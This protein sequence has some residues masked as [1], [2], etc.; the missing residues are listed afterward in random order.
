VE[1][2]D[3]FASLGLKPKEQEWKHG[4]E[5]IEGIKKGVEVFAGAEA[6]KGIY[7][8]VKSTGEAAVAALRLG[9]KIGVSTEAVQELGY[10]A[11]VSGVNAEELQHG[12]QHLALGLQEA[13]T[14]GTGPLVDG[15]HTLG[16]SFEAVRN[17]TPDEMLAVLA[18]RFATMPD[19]A[20]KTAAAMQIFG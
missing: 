2:A 14:K 12:F 1:V 8:M 17:K 9:Q 20:K 4:H 16:V 19:G 15:L 3:L 13:R 18:D 5:L 10:A 6:V 7:E 11:K